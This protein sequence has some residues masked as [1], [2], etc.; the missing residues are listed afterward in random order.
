MSEVERKGSWTRRFEKDRE[1]WIEGA[2]RSLDLIQ[3][4][5]GWCNKSFGVWPADAFPSVYGQYGVCRSL[6]LVLA[7]LSIQL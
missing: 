4:L 1:N 2:S 3:A 7:K 6:Y 5:E